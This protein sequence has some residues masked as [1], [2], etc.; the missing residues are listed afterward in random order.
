[1]EQ[2]RDVPN[3]EGLYQISI[4]TKEGKCRRIFKNGKVKELSNNPN[5]KFGRIYW[6]LCKD[7]VSR[8]PQAAVWIALTYPEYVQNE[9]FEG[10]EIEHIDT[11]RLNNHPSNLKWVTRKQNLNNPL[12]IK[13]NSDAQ[14]GKVFTPEHKE[15][16]SK[17]LKQIN[18]IKKMSLRF[19]PEALTSHVKVA[20]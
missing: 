14:K 3:Y 12:T 13:H 1:M 17:S 18:S 2:W 10:A 7:G 8:K 5:K 11:D 9:W 6:G 4:D 16:I 19:I 15:K 20:K